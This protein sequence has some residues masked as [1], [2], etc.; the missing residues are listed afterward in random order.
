[1]FLYCKPL[2]AQTFFILCKSAPNPDDLVGDGGK[3]ASG[4][5][6]PDPE[7]L[8]HLSCRL[9]SALGILFRAFSYWESGGGGVCRG[10]LF[11]C[12]GGSSD[13][14]RQS[15]FP[16]RARRKNGRS[17]TWTAPASTA[18]PCALSTLLAWAREAK[19]GRR[20]RGVSSNPTSCGAI[21]GGGSPWR[22]C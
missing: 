3:W 6:G 16:C 21:V 5:D 15:G 9:R 4:G 10:K 20:R 19:G 1:M 13:D 8:L 11:C 22:S 7:G 17:L 14:H 12:L 18:L 2:G